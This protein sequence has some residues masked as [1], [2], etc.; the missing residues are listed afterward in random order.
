MRAAFS[1]TGITGSSIK[2]GSI[3]I[4]LIAGV[5]RRGGDAVSQQRAGESI[6]DTGMTGRRT[7]DGSLPF[8]VEAHSSIYAVTIKH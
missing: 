1:I 3:A 4:R 7:G 2:E 5:L 6:A 8:I